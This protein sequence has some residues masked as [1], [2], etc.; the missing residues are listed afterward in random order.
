MK[1]DTESGAKYSR[2]ISTPVDLE[3]FEK[4]RKI[5]LDQQVPMTQIVR[6]AID[7]FLKNDKNIINE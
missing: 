4:I 5:T 7:A 6:K 2:T 3:V 1:N